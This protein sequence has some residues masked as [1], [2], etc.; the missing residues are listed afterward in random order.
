DDREAAPAFRARHV[1]FAVASLQLLDGAL[2]LAAGGHDLALTGRERGKLRAAGPGGEVRVRL[3]GRHALDGS[4]DTDLATELVPVEAERRQRVCLELL[5][6]TTFV[7]REEDEAALVGRLQQHEARR[8]PA[9][10]T[11]RGQRER[12][13]PGHVRLPRRV[14]PGVELTQR[15]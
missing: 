1:A 2:E 4:L 13:R 10:R 15:I 7:A 5:S 12:F 9:V 8:R 3:A 14:V 6:L 11:G